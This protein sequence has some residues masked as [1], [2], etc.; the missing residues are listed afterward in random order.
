MILQ[1]YAFYLKTETGQR[2][3][4]I[5]DVISIEITWRWN[6]VSKWTMT[7]AGLAPCPLGKGAEIIVY[8]GEEPYLSGYVTE[9][10]DSFDAASGIYD[11]TVEGQDDLGKLERRVIYP[12]PSN[13][14]VQWDREYSAEGSAA[15]VLLDLIRRNIA[16]LADLPERRIVT[17]TTHDKEGVGENVTVAAEYDTL[18]DF[19]LDQ[20]SDGK[21]GIR[22]VWN[23][24]TGSSEIQIYLPEDVSLNVIFSVEAGSLAGWTRTRTA[25]KGNVLLVTGCEVKE[26]DEEES[27][28]DESSE[29]APKFYQTVIVIDEESVR[30]WGRYELKIDHGDIKRIEE[31]DEDTGEVTYQE[32]WESV[33]ERL[34]QAALTDLENNSAE[35]GYELTITELDRMQYK[36]HWDLGDTVSVRIAD[37]EFLAPIKEIKVTYAEGIETVT[38]SVGKLQKGE[39]QSVFDELGN[40]KQRITVIQK[41]EQKKDT[42]ISKLE[43]V[44]SVLTTWANEYEDDEEEEPPATIPE[45]AA[46][47]ETV[48]RQIGGLRWAILSL[49]R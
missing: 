2:G 8:R 48:K 36:K 25:P 29:D 5:N 9:I 20:L 39:L 40:L 44:Q 4:M 38:P 16:D 13:A 15:D 46:S 41:T 24:E 21:L 27:A 32:S 12:D 30:E 49:D 42:D 14:D 1:D 47:L 19:V 17:L 33:A 3:A 31:K 35:D 11:W 18:L 23:G 37:T 45:V 28:E 6:E 34:R 10:E 7:G 43:E 22:A 26:N